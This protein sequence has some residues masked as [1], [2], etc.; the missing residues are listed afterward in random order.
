MGLA[1][2][3][4]KLS[5]KGSLGVLGKLAGIALGADGLHDMNV[6]NR[7]QGVSPVVGPYNP[8]YD[9]NL[10]ESVKP[11]SQDDSYHMKR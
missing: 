9:N 1:G 10:I 3:A 2:L 6:R 7:N 8:Y 4:F 5:G 11:V